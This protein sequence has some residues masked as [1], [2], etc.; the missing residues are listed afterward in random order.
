MMT[1]EL[2]KINDL[3]TN[4]LYVKIS[5]D[6]EIFTIEHSSIEGIIFISRIYDFNP[7]NLQKSLI[8]SIRVLEKSGNN[9]NNLILRKS[10]YENLLPYFRELDIDNLLDD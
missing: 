10:A 6:G 8:K 3:L 5:H 9:K 1:K 4:G 2:Y 7:V